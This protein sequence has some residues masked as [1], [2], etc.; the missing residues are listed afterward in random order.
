LHPQFAILNGKY[1]RH[2]FVTIFEMQPAGGL[3]AVFRRL[4]FVEPEQ[5]HIGEQELEGKLG[6]GMFP[7]KTVCFID[8]PERAVQ[9]G[10]V[11]QLQKAGAGN[12]IGSK[13]AEG[14]AGGE[15]D[16]EQK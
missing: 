8:L 4:G 13:R 6:G 15:E 14:Q 3:V 1:I 11:K 16:G 10:A 5:I 7:G 9:R 12:A 2:D